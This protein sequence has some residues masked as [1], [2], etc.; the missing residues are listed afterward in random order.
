MNDT[1]LDN[2]Y[3]YLLQLR[4][5]WQ[6]IPGPWLH[7]EDGK[8]KTQERADVVGYYDLGTILE[9]QHQLCGSSQDQ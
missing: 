1:G 6:I 3:H 8:D 2:L 4:F 9:C 7:V 5:N